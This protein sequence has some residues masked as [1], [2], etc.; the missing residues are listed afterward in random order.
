[1]SEDPLCIILAR[2][3]VAI[4]QDSG[5]CMLEIEAALEIS[6]CIVCTLPL[7][8]VNA[9]CATPAPSLEDS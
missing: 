5:A 2:Q 4:I 1:M 7:P 9:A 3:I 6:K 8:L